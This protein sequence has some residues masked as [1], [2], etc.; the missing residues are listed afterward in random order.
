[1]RHSRKIGNGAAVLIGVLMTAGCGNL[2][3]PAVTDPG[4]P[5][6]LAQKVRG[7]WM[8]GGVRDGTVGSAIAQVD[9][10]DP[11]TSTWY[12]AV[13][14]LPTPVSFGAAAGYTRPSDGHHLIVVIGGFDA[15]GVTQNIVQI[16]DLEE[17]TW[18]SG[19][20]M[21]QARAN[22]H[23]TL[24]DDK[25]YILGGSG[26]GVATGATTAW[27][28]NATTYEYAVGSTWNTKVSFGA[29]ATE[30][31]SYAYDGVVYDLI[32]RT[33]AA[34]FVTTHDG[35]SI[36]ANLLTT[37]LTEV[38][39]P[40]ARAGVAGALWKASTPPSYVM[41]V[42]GYTAMTGSSQYF[43]PNSVTASTP[44]NSVYVLAY[45]FTAPS[46][47]ALMTFPQ[48]IGFGA[49]AI[50][51][52]TFYYFG[53]TTT[54]V[55]ASASGEVTVRYANLAALPGAVTWSSASPMPVG[56]YGHSAV[57]FPQ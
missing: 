13:A 35:I 21:T 47:W 36:A 11:E 24:V 54:L 10:L 9:M 32:G 14:S 34:T 42:G 7:I 41:L 17:A 43:V 33:A 39:F 1:M 46:T 6:T 48:A 56:R 55:P 30:R 57:T 44:S 18:S 52:N 29:A 22:I 20:S 45:P 2:L 12:P 50:H 37:G 4:P 38:V 19:T 28:G 27:A 23:A 53:G 51:G 40:S 5:P 3:L 16:Y 8:V 15:V 31:F 26:S 49:A 25:I